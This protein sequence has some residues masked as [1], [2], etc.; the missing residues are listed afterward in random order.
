MRR[1]LVTFIVTALALLGSGCSQDDDPAGTQS[2]PVELERPDEFEIGQEWLYRDPPTGFGGALQ[3]VG[4]NRSSSCGEIYLIRVRDLNAAGRWFQAW[5][6]QTALEHSA[7]EFHGT[8]PVAGVNLS[9]GSSDAA[10]F[11]EP[12]SML[13]SSVAQA[14]ELRD[15]LRTGH[16]SVE[17]VQ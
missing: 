12:C 6:T 2:T 1:L 9:T 7:A 17:A 4:V 14:L 8:P 10:E 5:I 15:A 16:Q 13:G 11:D 3:I